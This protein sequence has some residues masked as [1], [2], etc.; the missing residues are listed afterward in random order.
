[1]VPG[2]EAPHFTKM[3]DIHTMCA[4]G[5]QERTGEEYADLSERAGWAYRVPWY[6][7]SRFIGVV[8]AART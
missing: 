6:P 1:M 8:E 4:T 7:P 3:F 5:G 2:S